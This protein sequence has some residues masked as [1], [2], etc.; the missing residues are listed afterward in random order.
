MSD[1]LPLVR[2][3]VSKYHVLY[4]KSNCDNFDDTEEV[5]T[6]TRICTKNTPVA[7]EACKSANA[8]DVHPRTYT[9]QGSS[10]GG[11][12][13]LLICRFLFLSTKM[14]S[15]V[16]TIGFTTAHLCRVRSGGGGSPQNVAFG[17]ARYF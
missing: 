3:L 8:L 10:Q 2:V 13:G 6:Y 1:S 14:Q 16:T 9:H 17:M 4:Q 15:L 11:G 12:G 7:R 5:L